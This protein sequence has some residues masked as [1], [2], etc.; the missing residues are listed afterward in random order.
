MDFTFHMPV[1]VRSGEGC[2]RT[3]GPLLR[4]LGRRC[5]IITGGHGAKESGALDDLLAVLKDSRIDATIFP[6]S[7]KTRWFPSA[8]RRPGP[9]RSAG[10]IS[11]SGWAAAR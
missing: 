3:A 4:G 8:S 11:S 2:V 9:R 7:A 6:A 5:L 10:P 1:D